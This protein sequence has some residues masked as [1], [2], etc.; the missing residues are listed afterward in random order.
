MTD[1]IYYK[2]QYPLK[3][4][5]NM[6]QNIDTEDPFVGDGNIET[7]KKGLEEIDEFLERWEKEGK[8]SL[9]TII[10]QLRQT[11]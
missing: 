10:R 4:A 8:E 9:Q 1:Q 7:M 6:I 3:K 5:I 11:Q 2:I